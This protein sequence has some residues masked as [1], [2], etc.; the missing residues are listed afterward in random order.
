MKNVSDA[1]KQVISAGGPFYAYAEVQLANSEKLILTSQNDFMAD[2]CSYSESAGVSSFPLG[3]AVAKTLQI[4]IDNSDE[5][6]SGYDFYGARITLYTEADLPDG[7]T[8]RIKEGTFTVT[9]P[10]A[11]GDILN[12]TAV[13]DMGKTDIPY[14]PNTALPATVLEIV[15]DIC[16][17]CDIVLGSVTFT[18][19]D[20]QISELPSDTNCRTILGYIAQIAGGNAFCDENNRLIIKSY[21]TAVFDRFQVLDGGNFDEEVSDIVDGGNFDE[22]VSGV[23]DGGE[24]GEKEEYHQ[25]YNFSDDP[26][27]ASDD[28]V[29]TGIEITIESDTNEEETYLY[30]QEGYVLSI[31]NP[32][33][34]GKEKEVL[35]KIG[36]LIIGLQIRPFSGNFFP[37]PRIEFMDAAVLIDRKDNSYMSFITDNEFT[38]LDDQSLSNSTESPERNNA[39]YYSAS[40]AAYRK[41]REKIKKQRTEFEKAMEELNDRINNSSGLYMTADVQPD[42]STIYYLH[43][44]PTLKESKIVWKMTA[45]AFGVSTDG[46]KTWNAGLTVDGTL[47]AKIL[48]TIGINADWINTGSLLADFIR[49]GTLILGGAGNKNGVLQ[50]QG[51][52]GSQIGK[53]DSDGIEAQGG[54][55]NRNS[56]GEIQARFER[57][58]IEFE[59]AGDD[60]YFPGIINISLTKRD[61]GKYELNILQNLSLGDKKNPKISMLIS[62][63]SLT[64]QSSISIYDQPCKTGTVNLPNGGY[65]T[66]QEGLITDFYNP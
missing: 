43:D 61:L 64:I 63:N 53:W 18:N 31:D 51:S 24:F 8:E 19:A 66:F 11:V 3:V 49:G 44:K 21:D 55:S 27:I 5:R 33:I 7:K 12:I 28:V 4:K 65:I 58:M 57:G 13:N 25:L 37:D 59:T 22:F 15:R 62:L 17:Q 32:L 23:L 56:S 6:Y 30:G 54:I 35:K 40:T 1:F 9:D 42:G 10:V 46:G 45:E 60:T 14:S 39:S 48:N 16:G 50:I 34:A 20:V 41:A 2:G 29:I 47:I 26:E 52:D 38:Y 36:D